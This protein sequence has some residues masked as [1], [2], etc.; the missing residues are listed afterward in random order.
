M[1]LAGRSAP[2]GGVAR[3][4]PVYT[5]PARRRRGYGSAVTARATQAAL[6]AGANDVVLYTDLSNPT[7]NAIYQSIGY[8]ADHDSQERSLVES[9]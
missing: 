9:S 5:P 1:A 4:G 6:Q 7:S 8:V 3:I 2:A